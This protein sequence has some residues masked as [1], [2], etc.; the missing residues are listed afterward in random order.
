MVKMFKKK[1]ENKKKNKNKKKTSGSL[2]YLL[3]AGIAGGVCRS[4]IPTISWL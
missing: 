1:K 4:A 2:L 3:G